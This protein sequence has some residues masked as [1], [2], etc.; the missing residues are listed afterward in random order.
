MAYTAPHSTRL[1][2]IRQDSPFSKGKEG[3][4]S[5]VCEAHWQG[6]KL[7][8]KGE[9]ENIGPVG[10]KLWG[11]T[12]WLEGRGT[13]TGPQ[14][15]AQRHAGDTAA[16]LKPCRGELR[17]PEV[18]GV[19]KEASVKHPKGNKWCSSV[20]VTRTTAQMKYLYMNAHSMG[21][22]REEMEATGL[23]ESYN[24]IALT[25]TWWHESHYWSVAVDG[26]RLFRK[27]RWGKRGGGI[28]LYIKK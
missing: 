18:V 25:E 20:K 10:D 1:A 13:C 14:P 5:G 3:L 24:L 8:V 6:F 22:K 19:K 21:K 9:G 16:Q 23:L 4:C 12:Q 7:N 27:H 28:S 26:Y 15:L 17:A 11:D 2:G